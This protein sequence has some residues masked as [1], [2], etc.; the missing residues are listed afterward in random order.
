VWFPNSPKRFI[1]SPILG[2]IVVGKNGVCNRVTGR[3]A[4]KDFGSTATISFL[5]GKMKI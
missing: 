4:S 3:Y 2:V 5:K 1:P